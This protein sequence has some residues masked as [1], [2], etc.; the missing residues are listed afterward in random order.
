[1]LLVLRKGGEGLDLE[2]DE[3]KLK[4]ILLEKSGCEEEGIY[5]SHGLC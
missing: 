5:L 1:M 2:L 4:I 3:E